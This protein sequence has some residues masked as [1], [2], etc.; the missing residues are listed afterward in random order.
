[1][2][3]DNKS[4]LIFIERMDY[5]DK[6]FAMSLLTHYPDNASYKIIISHLHERLDILT[7]FVRIVTKGK[8]IIISLNSQPPFDVRRQSLDV[9]L[10]D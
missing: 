4:R 3:S 1:M 8:E 9:P 7:L 5:F 2:L 6:K 10:I